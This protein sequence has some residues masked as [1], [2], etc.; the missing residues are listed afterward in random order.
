[1]HNW[2]FGGWDHG[3]EYE[4]W[5][6]HL[7][8]NH[9]FGANL[10]SDFFE[11]ENLTFS[12]WLAW[13]RRWMW[14]LDKR[15]GG[16]ENR[17]GSLEKRSL[18]LVDTP[19]ITWEKTGSWGIPEVKWNA[20]LNMMTWTFPENKIVEKGNV[21]LSKS[22]EIRKMIDGTNEF[23]W[24]ANN[25]LSIKTDGVYAPSDAEGINH[26]FHLTNE[27]EKSLNII[28]A[29]GS[30]AVDGKLSTS[31]GAGNF[32][33][34]GSV[35]MN[36]PYTSSTGLTRIFF[37]TAKGLYF[38]TNRGES[39]VYVFNKAG[40]LI[41]VVKLAPANGHAID[42]ITSLF[43]TYEQKTAFTGWYLEIGTDNESA[44]LFKIPLA[45]VEGAKAKVDKSITVTEYNSL[46]TYYNVIG[47][48]NTWLSTQ[49]F[50]SQK[51]TL[52]NS[53]TGAFATT[54]RQ[55][56]YNAGAVTILQTTSQFTGVDSLASADHFGRIIAK[57]GDSTIHIFNV[58]GGKLVPKGTTQD[59]AQTDLVVNDTHNGGLYG[60]DQSWSKP[61]L[62]SIQIFNR[63][64]RQSEFN[65]DFTIT[66][67]PEPV[68][69]KPNTTGKAAAYRIYAFGNLA[70]SLKEVLPNHK[71]AS[72]SSK[73]LGSY[74][75]GAGKG[76]AGFSFQGSFAIGGKG[77]NPVDSPDKQ[78]NLD[79]ILIG[80][81]TSDP[82]IL[83]NGPMS[84]WTFKQTITYHRQG[85]TTNAPFDREVPVIVGRT[86]RLK[87]GTTSEII[88]QWTVVDAQW[89]TTNIHNA[90]SLAK[91][92]TTLTAGAGV[93]LTQTTNSNGGINYQVSS[94]IG[95]LPS[96]TYNLAA[97]KSIWNGSATSGTA[98][99]DFTSGTYEVSWTAG[100]NGFRTEISI[101]TATGN[102]NIT[103]Q[104][105]NDVDGAQGS[106]ETYSCHIRVAANHRDWT[107]SSRFV[108]F[109]PGG[110][111]S[112][113]GVT[114]PFIVQDISK[115]VTVPLT[116]G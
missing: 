37:D 60:E 91:Q 111:T 10:I 51:I 50:M 48:E 27:L 92:H 114:T 7:P 75:D 1:M 74:T 42:N 39:V 68:R 30:S 44:F 99:E 108:L 80:Y 102:D 88:G 57:S 66:A 52:W 105:V 82:Q 12:Q 89:I 100:Q 40:D 54:D 38:A 64:R 28:I 59:V 67:V 98:S 46:E 17:M 71:N 34:V 65:G 49:D 69:F 104:T 81:N 9:A 3:G 25:E 86:V 109:P 77:L 96:G 20:E 90:L 84:D 24:V 2:G 62:L 85:D 78:T 32:S 6:A 93:K 53:V 16:I 15:M 103:W 112:T 116:F 110:A 22:T 115:I 13:L 58:E 14:A 55:N 101:V 36:T 33:E 95:N 113:N 35:A 47:S 21:N 83:E 73:D 79:G 23:S 11:N 18:D 19:S 107:A 106:Q 97:K 45:D 41:T 56:W 94:A 31:L 61:K 4:R 63:A 29:G 5:W 72:I 26:L 87:V 76:L 70:S 43:L 8:Y